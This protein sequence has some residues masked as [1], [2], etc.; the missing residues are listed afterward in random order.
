MLRKSLDTL[1]KN[2]III[3]V[4][5][6]VTVILF[7]A[8]ILILPDIN[9]IT[10]ISNEITQTQVDP[11]TIDPQ[12]IID[13]MISGMK[14]LLFGLIVCIFGIIYVSGFGNMMSEAVIEGKTSIKSFFTGIKRSFKKTI[15]SFLL[16][17]AFSFGFG[18]IVALI[19]MPFT[20]SSMVKSSFDNQAVYNDQRIVQALS[21]IIS[22]FAYPFV[23]LWFPSIF[24][25]KNDGVIAS[26][27]KGLRAGIKNYKLLVVVT[28]A[29]LLPSIGLLVF[30]TGLNTI[31][32]VAS[33]PAYI[34]IYIY[35]ALLA[36]VIFIYLFT[37]YN[38]TRQL[39]Q[40]ME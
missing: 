20:I 16:L 5:L 17:I 28:A 8:I 27:K 33:S 2:P 21:S 3:F 13:M 36:P 38:K 15:L 35:Q 32:T 9:K 29:M 39:Q 24:M 1:K 37:L 6:L 31:N 11:S 4:Y 40:N 23:E 26:L 19:S 30:N 14:L 7:L 18:I 34:A 22:I 25:D 12:L 10:A